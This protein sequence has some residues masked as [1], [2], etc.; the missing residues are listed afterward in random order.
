MRRLERYT[1]P[2]RSRPITMR[3]ARLDGRVCGQEHADAPNAL[4]LLR[5]RREG[6]S[7]RRA[8]EQR[9]ERAPLHS[10]TSSASASSLSGISKPSAFAV[11][12]LMT[13]SNL[14]GWIT[15]RFAGFSPLRIRPA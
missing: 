15:G 13:N 10:I 9:D 14:V 8:T 7:G 12:R 5:S 4:A 11:M 2:L 6:P 1:D 3:A